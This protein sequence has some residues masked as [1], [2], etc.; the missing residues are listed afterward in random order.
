L[1]IVILLANIFYMRKISNQMNVGIL[2]FGN[3]GQAI[4][5][6]LKNQPAFAKNA[7]FF[8]CSPG[9]NH[10]KGATCRKNKEDL[11]EKCGLVFLCVKPQEFFRMKF[12]KSFSENEPVLISIM[13]GVNLK[14]IKKITGCRK[15]VR[16]MPNLPLQIGKGFTGWHANKEIFSKNEWKFIENIFLYFGKSVFVSDES[17]VDAITAISGSGPAYVFLF[18]DALIKSAIDL[19]FSKNQAEEMVIETIMGSTEYFLKIH[20]KTSLEKLISMVKSKNGTTEAALNEIGVSDYYKRW[21]NAVAKAHQRAKE[22]SSY[23]IK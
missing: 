13:A 23:E 10:T 9:I 6:L 2:G 16:A 21:Q 12:Q 22:I 14:N 11:F 17:K 8:I 1:K 5:R 3:M 20:S 7:K 19:G 4:F 18:L 15:V